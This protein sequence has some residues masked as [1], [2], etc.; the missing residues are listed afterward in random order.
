M[1]QHLAMIAAT[2][3]L[4]LVPAAA[5]A[6]EARPAEKGTF[7]GLLFGP[8]PKPGA[9]ADARTGPRSTSAPSSP[10][11]AP[12]P[13]KSEG[14]VITY[15]LPGSPAAKAG[16]RRSDVLLQYDRVKVRDCEQLAVLIRDDKPDRKVKLLVV[17]DK[18]ELAVDATLALGPALKL[19]PSFREGPR[20]SPPPGPDPVKTT[21]RSVTAATNMPG[22]PAGG[23]AIAPN[24]LG[25]VRIV[26][27]PLDSG[28]M[29]LTM[30]FYA[31]GRLQQTLTCQGAADDLAK[32]VQKL[33]ERERN[34]V[35]VALERLRTI[36]QPPPLTTPRPAPSR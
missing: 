24:S 8:L 26:A 18:R 25:S 21:V 29:K 36:N 35:R 13:V 7:L 34:L 4:A 11:A 1:T 17:R 19:A 27:T 31:D 33:P 16:L 12:K 10:T 23:A 9:S 15:V 30:A 6:E 3:V 28:K 20:T 14:V 22:E 32:T 5:R 2:L